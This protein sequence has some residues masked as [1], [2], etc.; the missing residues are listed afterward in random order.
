MYVKRLKHDT[1][2]C[3]SRFTSRWN[4]VRMHCTQQLHTHDD[5]TGRR[6]AAFQMPLRIHMYET[7]PMW[8]SSNH[9]S[10][11]PNASF[12]LSGLI[13]RLH[14]HDD[15]TR[16]PASF[17]MALRPPRYGWNMADMWH[18][19]NHHSIIPNSSFLLPWLAATPSSLFSL[20]PTVLYWQ[21]LHKLK[22]QILAFEI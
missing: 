11:F 4:A 6:P 5:V 9:H 18:S 15:V 20:P 7:L 13:P 12:L 10:F 16:R 17:L 3:H 1:G 19:S 22:R 21:R 14:T 2:L 8:H